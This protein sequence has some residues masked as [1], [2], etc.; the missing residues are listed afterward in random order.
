MAKSRS[1]TVSECT[2]FRPDFALIGHDTVSR[3]IF[4]FSPPNF[5]LPYCDEIPRRA[6]V[7]ATTYIQSHAARSTPF[8]RDWSG[9][10]GY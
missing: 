3:L 1:H 6:T 7:L 5:H 10:C 4:R 9:R 8:S 2:C